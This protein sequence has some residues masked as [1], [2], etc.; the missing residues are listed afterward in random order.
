MRKPSPKKK[1]RGVRMDGIG[2]AKSWND[3]KPF[4]KDY[5][6]QHLE[7]KGGKFICPICKS[8]TGKN[9]TSA[10]SITKDGL[11]WHCYSGNHPDDQKGGDIFDLCM[12]IE[13][14]N[15]S[16]SFLKVQEFCTG[17]PGPRR[18]SPP[19]QS[20]VKGRVDYWD[21]FIAAAKRIQ[22]TDYMT[23]RGISLETL[24]KFTIGYAPAWRH[25]RRPKTKLSPR[26]I[27]PAGKGQYTARF[28]GTSEDLDELNK[29]IHPDYQ[30]AKAEKV[31]TQDYVFNSFALKENYVFVVEGEID[32]L[33]IEEVGFH[34]IATGGEA[35][36]KKVPNNYKEA[37]STSFLIVAMDS[38]EA[39]ST[40]GR[41]LD[42]AL[43]E[44]EI[45]HI[46][47][48]RLWSSAEGLDCNDAN[49]LLQRDRETLKKVLAE[50]IERAKAEERRR[51]EEARAEEEAER[52][53][54][55]E[56]FSGTSILN[57][58]YE[59]VENLRRHGRQNIPTG[60]QS[61]DEVLDGGLLPGTVTTIGG[62]TSL[63][64]TT[65]I[66][67]IAESMAAGGTDALVISLEMEKIRLVA[68]SISR[69]T[70]ANSDEDTALTMGDVIS[71]DRWD[72]L[73][74]RQSEL[75]KNAIEEY[76]KKICPHL[77][78]KEVLGEF[79]VLD[80]RE[81]VKKHIRLMGRK[82][83]LFVDYL[84]QLQPIDNKLN[85]TQMIDENM[86]KLDQMSRELQIAVVLV[87]SFNRSSYQKKAAF[88]GFR[89]SGKIEY[90]SRVV[91]GLQLRGI[92]G[93]NFDIDEA[94]SKNPREIELVVLKN[95]FG[96]V[97]NKLN[98]KYFAKF[99][100]YEED[101]TE[102]NPGPRRSIKRGTK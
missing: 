19:S 79:T 16:E 91:L 12:F 36:R 26:I 24:Q 80:L 96:V 58:L 38:D 44:N 90:S 28:I 29:D 95:S 10:F 70:F 67:Q 43:T 81:L 4:L 18:F 68:K 47:E 15:R 75:F 86:K 76:S 69:I 41:L 73:T 20:E 27:L 88:E 11:K 45:P 85:D 33:S 102:S 37:K 89:D 54:Y 30:L 74:E 77:F 31:G 52:L 83:V 92:G 7:K 17:K 6:E 8:G 99:N 39:G 87:S 61:L 60:F 56:E 42:Q 3:Y 53:K 63:G 101:S 35:V 72:S 78:I 2:K 50:S 59:H 100:L 25:P 71:G 82:P 84:Q 32:A 51:E 21:F 13:N 48:E 1:E 65:F 57:E 34:A 94:K 93:D 5:C 40:E 23:K 55:E 49:E 66:M 22:Q 14:C 97:G 9:G 64:K 62:I 98:F 46:K